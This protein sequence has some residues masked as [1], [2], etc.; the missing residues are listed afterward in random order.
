MK[1][2]RNVYLTYV[3]VVAL[4][5]L[6]LTLSPWTAPVFAGTVTWFVPLLAAWLLAAVLEL[7]LSLF[8]SLPLSFA[9]EAVMGLISLAILS[10][11]TAG[12]AY[13]LF[14]TLV[15]TL[16]VLKASEQFAG[17]DTHFHHAPTA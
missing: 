13:V 11:L 6:F 15:P 14:A 4:A 2:V 16:V 9:A 10:T 12:V 1:V 3:V 5:H 7:V 8:D 17:V